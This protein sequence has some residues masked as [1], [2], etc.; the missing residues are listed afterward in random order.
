MPNPQLDTNYVFSRV[1]TEPKAQTMTKVHSE[2]MTVKNVLFITLFS[3]LTY[4]L[5][6]IGFLL[7]LKPIPKN[8]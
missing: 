6:S 7:C 8:Y 2:E 5:I 3:K 1:A 4:S